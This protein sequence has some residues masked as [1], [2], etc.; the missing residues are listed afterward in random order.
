MELFIFSFRFGALHFFFF[1]LICWSTVRE[2]N[3]Y[4]R[5]LAFW[6]VHTQILTKGKCSSTTSLPI[7]LNLTWRFGPLTLGAVLTIDSVWGG[8][9]EVLLADCDFS[10]SFLAFLRRSQRAVSLTSLRVS[11]VMRL[12]LAA[13]CTHFNTP[14]CQWPCWVWPKERTGK[15]REGQAIFL[16]PVHVQM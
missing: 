11:W 7:N 1:F 12:L 8:E 10:R 2:L 3:G 5:N 13:V 15:V 16:L 6:L 9:V 4:E 14:F